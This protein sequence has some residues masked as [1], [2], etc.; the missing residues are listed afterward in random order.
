MKIKLIVLTMNLCFTINS[1]AQIVKD[2]KIGKQEW[3]GDY[4]SV[5]TFKNGDSIPFAATEKDWRV[6][7]EKKNLVTPF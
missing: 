2:I 4:L 1:F 6:A 7:G 5:S 3:K